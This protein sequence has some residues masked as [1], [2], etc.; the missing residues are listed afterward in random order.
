MGGHFHDLAAGTATPKAYEF[1]WNDDVIAINQFADVLKSATEAVSSALNTQ[2]TGIP[3]VV[4][5]PLN[6]ER[7]DPVEAAVQFPGGTPEPASRHRPGW[8]RR[9]RP[10]FRTESHLRGHACPRWA[11]PST[12][13]QPERSR[14]IRPERCT[15]HR[16]LSKISITACAECRR[17]HRQHLRQTARQRTTRCPYAARH[18]LRQSRAM[19]GLEHGLGPGAGPAQR[20]RQRPGDRF[21]SSRTVPHALHSKLRAKPPARN[22]SRP[23]SFPPVTPAGALRSQTRLTGTPA[24]LI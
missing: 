3:I 23:F 21:A 22:S 5:N 1:A 20:V 19:A 6:I 15:S 10:D 24:S 2:T 7:E 18:L 16:I 13:V 8:Q 9:P 11:M 12:S 4:Y 17:R 14:E